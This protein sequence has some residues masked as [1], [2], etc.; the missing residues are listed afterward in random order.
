[1]WARLEEKSAEAGKQESC[2]GC[3]W[4][5]M[6]VQGGVQLLSLLFTTLY[7]FY[8][9]KNLEEPPNLEEPHADER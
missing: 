7:L 4:V 3:I 2:T 1:M 6:S 8:F 5:G 9:D